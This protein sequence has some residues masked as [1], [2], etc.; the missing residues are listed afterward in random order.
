M[1]KI[2]KI[3]YFTVFMFMTQSAAFN[4]NFMLEIR[5]FILIFN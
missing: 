3:S 1:K 5:P 4:F 2:W